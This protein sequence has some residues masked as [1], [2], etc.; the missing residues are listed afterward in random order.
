MTDAIGV[1]ANVIG[2]T[3]TLPLDLSKVWSQAGSCVTKSAVSGYIGYEICAAKSLTLTLTKAILLKTLIDDKSSF[4][5]FAVVPVIYSLFTPL[6]NALVKIQTQ[7]MAKDTKIGNALEAFK[8]ASNA[9]MFRGVEAQFLRGLTISGAFASLP[10]FY[11][12]PPGN[13]WVTLAN[14]SV[15]YSLGTIFAHPFDL[16]RVNLQKCGSTSSFMQVVSETYKAQGFLGF[17]RG[18]GPAVGRTV[19]ASGLIL[20]INNQFN[21]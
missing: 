10:L 1:L 6:D 13:V 4:T 18:V 19:L 12:G 15:A 2:T 14:F 16:I 3:L 7:N 20:G 9:G 11:S 21:D 17:Y 5:S 8:A